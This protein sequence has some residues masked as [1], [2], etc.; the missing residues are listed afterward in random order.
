MSNSN[1]GAT[2]LEMIVQQQANMYTNIP[3]R[4]I[5]WREKE[6]VVD[7]EIVVKR[8]YPNGFSAEPTKVYD[9]PVMF[10]Q[11]GSWTIAGEMKKGDIVLLVCPMFNIEDWLVG[12]QKRT[13][14]SLGYQL[15]NLDGA[16]ALAGCFNY[17]NPTRDTRFLGKFHIVKGKNYLVMDD[18]SIIIEANGGKSR[19]EMLADGTMNITTDAET[20][21]T[22]S[23]TNINNDTTINGNLQVNG[24]QNT[25]GTNTTVGVVTSQTGMLSPSY[26]GYGGAGTMTIGTATINSATIDTSTIDTAVIGGIDFSSHTHQDSMGGTT[27]PPQ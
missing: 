24:N 4:V 22:S 3:A 16:F 14:N 27:S 21:I 19:I 8:P 12:D 9:V 7:V 18:T 26:S 20:N 10:M 5:A 25:S 11:G 6:Q 1:L 23:H 17:A 2:I 15:H 13:Y